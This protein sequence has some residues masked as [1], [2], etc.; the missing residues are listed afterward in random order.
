[1][2]ERGRQDSNPGPS[3]SIWLLY[4]SATAPYAKVYL[5]KGLFWCCTIITVT[6]K[7]NVSALIREGGGVFLHYIS[8]D[9]KLLPCFQARV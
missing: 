7:F 3:V 9:W 1:M 5:Y 4:L 2:K 8:T 6:E